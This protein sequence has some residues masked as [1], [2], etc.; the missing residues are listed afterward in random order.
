MSR[1]KKYIP[2]PA[3]IPKLIFADRD[4]GE[5]DKFV[6]C[7]DAGEVNEAEGSIISITI[8]GERYKVIPAMRGWAGFFREVAAI[9][10]VTDYDDTPMQTLMDKLENDELVTRKLIAEF[11]AVVEKQRAMYMHTPNGLINKVAYRELG[12][13]L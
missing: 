1:R 2:K 5:I 11:K 10:N 7:L 13:A 4:F 3:R 12:V 6:R 8:I 9:Q